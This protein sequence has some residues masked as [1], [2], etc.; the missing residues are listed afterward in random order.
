MKKS[1]TGKM[2]RV[3]AASVLATLVP[4]AVCFA[5]GESGGVHLFFK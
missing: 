2:R 1:T 3:L 5:E 4:G